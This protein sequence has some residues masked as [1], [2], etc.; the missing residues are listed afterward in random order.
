MNPFKSAFGGGY[1]AGAAIPRLIPQANGTKLLYEA[2][3]PFL[4]RR[5]ISA[6]VWEAGYTAGAMQRLNKQKRGF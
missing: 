3:N 6:M 2:V 1:R 5:V 4:P